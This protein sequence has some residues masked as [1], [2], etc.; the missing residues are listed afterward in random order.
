MAGQYIP[1]KEFEKISW[2]NRIK[3]KYGG[4]LKI[5]YHSRLMIVFSKRFSCIQKDYI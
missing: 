5:R 3:N 1:R 2:V 4:K